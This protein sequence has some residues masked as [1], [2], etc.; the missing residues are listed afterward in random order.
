MCKSRSRLTPVNVVDHIKP[1]GTHPHL[2]L[3]ESN[4]RSLCHVCHNRFGAKVKYDAE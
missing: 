3:V 1:V 2:R 4:C